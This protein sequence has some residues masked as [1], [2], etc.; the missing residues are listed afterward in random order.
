MEKQKF[1]LLCKYIARYDKMLKKNSSRPIG[2]CRL[3]NPKHEIL[4]I[5]RS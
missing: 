1:E 2:L 3:S 4:A 5:L